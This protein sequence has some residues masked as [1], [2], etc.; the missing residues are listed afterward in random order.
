MPGQENA[1]YAVCKHA[2][3]GL[4]FLSK[5]ELAVKGYF[6]TAKN[7]MC[8]FAATHVLARFS[9]RLESNLE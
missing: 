3:M 7:F 2:P 5:N 4:N 9:L 1:G 8:P 6:Y